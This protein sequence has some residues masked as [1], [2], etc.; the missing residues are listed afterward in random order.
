MIGMLLTKGRQ[1]T[2]IIRLQCTQAS[3]S[4]NIRLPQNKSIHG[5]QYTTRTSKK[6]NKEEEDPEF[7]EY[8]TMK[9]DEDKHEDEENEAKINMSAS[10]YAHVQT[11]SP[12]GEPEQQQ[13]CPENW[14]E[15][16]RPRGWKDNNSDSEDSCEDDDTRNDDNV[17]YLFVMLNVSIL[18]SYLWWF[19]TRFI[20]NYE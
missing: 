18:Q 14:L 1:E 20:S 2:R 13:S 3:S 4:E 10:T 11:S 5:R 9:E 8:Y 12:I 16:F 19:F 17:L 7:D 15:R 6:K